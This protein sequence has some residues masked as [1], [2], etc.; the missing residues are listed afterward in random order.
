MDS[1][2]FQSIGTNIQ[3]L[4]DY[5]CIFT[6]RSAIFHMQKQYFT[7]LALKPAQTI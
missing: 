2:M 6:G 3:T 4:F 7:Y 1:Y 5:L